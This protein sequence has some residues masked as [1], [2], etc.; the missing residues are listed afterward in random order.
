M[1]S[2]QKILLHIKRVYV[3][4]YLACVIVPNGMPLRYLINLKSAISWIINSFLH[5]IIIVIHS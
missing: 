2:Q 5:V 4:V 1:H 3:I